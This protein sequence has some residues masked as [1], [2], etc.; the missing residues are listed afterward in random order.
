METNGKHGRATKTLVL[1]AAC[2]VFSEVGYHD[3]TVARICEE[4]G[5][6]RAAVNYYYG[7]KQNLYREVWNHSYRLAQEA[8]PLRSTVEEASP[9]DRLR[10]FV[11]SLVLQ[12]FDSGPAGQFARIIAFEM[13]DPMEFLTEE[14]TRIREDI[15]EIFEGITRGLVGSAASRD[16]LALCR[17]MVLAPSL[18]IGVR[19]F[20]CHAKRAPHVMFESDPEEMAERMCQFALAGIEG[21]RDSIRLRDAAGEG[22]A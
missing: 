9:E 12:A 11:R 3:G 20:G 15:F 14:R 7:D 17:I 6:N 2:R 18:G 10:A 19:R 1:E 16:D 21:I 22:G 8:H 5:A 4:A 13:A